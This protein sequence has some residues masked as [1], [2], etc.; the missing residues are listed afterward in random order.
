MI[1]N[2]FKIALRNLLKYKGHSLINI[3]G[4]AIGVASCILIAFYIQHELSYDRFFHNRDRLFRVYMSLTV[5]GNLDKSAGIEYPIAPLLRQFPEVKEVARVTNLSKYMIGTIPTIHYGDQSFYEEKFYFADSTLFAVLGLP[6]AEGDPQRALLS[7][8]SVVITKDIARKYFGDEPPLGKV[9]R[10]NNQVDLKVTGVLDVFPGPSHIDVDFLASM[11]AMHQTGLPR[12]N[13][14]FPQ[15]W[16]LNWFFTYVLLENPEDAP[17]LEEKLIAFAHSNYTDLHIQNQVKLYVQPVRDIHL[18]SK[19]GIDITPSSDIRYVYIFG[20]IGALILAIACFNF[21]NLTIAQFTQRVR[22]L[23][24][25][26][27]LGAFRRQL[28]GQIL[29]ET[30]L[31]TVLASI[32]GLLLIELSIPLFHRLTGITAE[33]T[34]F[35]PYAMIFAPLLSIAAGIYPAIMFSSLQP[36]AALKDATRSFGKGAGLRKVLVVFQFSISVILIIGTLIVHE[37]LIFMRNK[38]TGFDRQHMLMIPLRGSRVE[39]Q[40]EVFKNRLL[41]NPNISNVSGVNGKLGQETRYTTFHVEGIATPQILTV[42][43][44]EYDFAKTFGLRIIEGRDFSKEVPTDAK[45]AFIINEAAMRQFGWNEAVGKQIKF[46]TVAGAPQGTII[47]VV[48]DFHFVSLHKDIGPLVI[49]Q[50]S[51]GYSAIKIREQRLPETL[52]F[53]ESTWK[54][55]DAEKGFIYSFLDDILNQNYQTEDRVSQLT[56]CF[57]ALAIFIACLGLLGLVSFSAARRTKEIGIRKVLGATAANLVRVLSQ[58]F[59]R[60][61]IIANFIAWPIAYWAMSNW[62]ENFAFRIELSG[63]TFLIAGVSAF[64]IALMTV[65]YQAIKAALANPVASLRYE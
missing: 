9:L 63:W 58:E 47:G 35:W 23:G 32:T 40:H 52:V 34:Q 21:I 53:I 54:E 38:D 48:K 59:L 55:F 41:Q 26:K 13:V 62:L 16:I 64:T 61:V 30:I 57:S 42:V 4:L 65:S 28:I 12:P 44:V 56:T 31:L 27:V 10:F 60:L 19:F 6:L 1:K 29:M 3:I 49:S 43:R 33:T 51:F 22:E 2:Y 45:E 36:T 37:Q 39:S 20:V 50:G 17:A 18:H 7:P 14:N 46:A 24:V 11:A 15:N 25:R 5:D 8:N